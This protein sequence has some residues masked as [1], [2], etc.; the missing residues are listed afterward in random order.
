MLE[1]YELIWVEF[2]WF[3]INVNDSTYSNSTWS[4]G[5]DIWMLSC[6]SMLTTTQYELELIHSTHKGLNIIMIITI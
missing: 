3:D 5:G 2:Q 6:K 1:N 4:D